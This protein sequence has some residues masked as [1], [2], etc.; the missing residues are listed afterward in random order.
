MAPISFRESLNNLPFRLVTLAQNLCGTF[1]YVCGLP[2]VG[3]ELSTSTEG[4]MERRKRS[5]VIHPSIQISWVFSIQELLSVS[6]I[7]GVMK[8][9]GSKLRMSTDLVSIWYTNWM[10]S[11][12]ICVFE[13]EKYGRMCVSKIDTKIQNASSCNSCPTIGV[14][15][16]INEGLMLNLMIVQD[17]RAYP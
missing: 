11:T 2:N 10:A 14:K 4:W 8:K 6:L 16:N 17:G 1:A 9:E 7:L 15:P 3:V 12:S 13:A 5:Y